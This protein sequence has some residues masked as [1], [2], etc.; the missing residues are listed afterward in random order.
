MMNLLP[1]QPEVEPRHEDNEDSW[2]VD[3]K[4]IVAKGPLY[5]QDYISTKI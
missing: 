3:L 1:V 5:T 4:Q 2:C